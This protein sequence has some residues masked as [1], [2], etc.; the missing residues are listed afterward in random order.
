MLLDPDEDWGLLTKDEV[1][2]RSDP[3]QP[4]YYNPYSDMYVERMAMAWWESS[5][6]MQAGPLVLSQRVL[7]GPEDE[8]EA[9]VDKATGIIKSVGCPPYKSRLCCWVCVVSAEPDLVCSRS[10]A[11][12]AGM[13]MDG[14]I[15]GVRE[16]NQTTRT[17]PEWHCQNSSGYRQGEPSVCSVAYSVMIVV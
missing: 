4:T 15:K 9:A 8:F 11:E 3:S 12:A 16:W 5:V 14:I 1:E 7:T 17:R 13:R 2:R 6:S 10:S